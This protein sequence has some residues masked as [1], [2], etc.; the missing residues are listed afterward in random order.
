MARP[1]QLSELPAETGVVVGSIAGASMNP[2][3]T[4]V[5]R[6]SD[7]KT[8][9]ERIISMRHSPIGPEFDFSEFE[10]SG[11]LF[12]FVLPAGTYAVEFARFENAGAASAYETGGDLYIPFT[13]TPGRILYLGELSFSPVES[14]DVGSRSHRPLLMQLVLRNEWGRDAVLLEARYPNVAWSEALLNPLLAS[15]AREGK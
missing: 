15:G 6:F 3:H 13:V 2:H 11:D 5:V 12:A 9:Q 8:R 10:R 14:A 4:F 1:E 7:K